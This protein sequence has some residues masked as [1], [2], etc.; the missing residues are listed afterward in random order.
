MHE[1]DQ[2]ASGPP[3]VFSA[4]K[5]LSKGEPQQDSSSSQATLPVQSSKQEENAL[6]A[7]GVAGLASKKLLQKHRVSSEQLRAASEQAIDCSA[8]EDD[9]D[10][11]DATSVGS[12]KIVEK[13][14]CVVQKIGAA[15]HSLHEYQNNKLR[16]ATKVVTRLPVKLG[17]KLFALGGGQR[18]V[19]MTAAVAA[20]FIFVL[21]KPVAHFVA[22]ESV[23][24]TRGA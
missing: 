23:N 10:D 14:L 1:D 2:A 7:L 18:T 22:N 24:M 12:N 19:A 8:I 15:R 21:A 4:W 3:A 20:A 13:A 11:D 5:W 6:Y 17:R 16:K 9:G